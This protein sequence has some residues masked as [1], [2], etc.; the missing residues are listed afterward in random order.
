VVAE[1][2]RIRELDINPLLATKEGLIALDARVVLHPWDV[3]DDRLPRPAIR[4]YPS[5]YVAP[6]TL[7]DGPEVMIRP[8]RPE[9]EPAMVAFHAA[10]S[11]E[12]V[13]MRYFATIPLETRTRHDALVRGCFIDYDR[14]MAL[15]AEQRDKV[16][17]ERRIIGVGRLIRVRETDDAEFAVAV[18]DQFQGQGL[19]TELL[20]RLVLIGKD[21]KV[22][23]IFGEILVENQ[24]MREVC[25]R[26]GF[27]F[28][29][30]RS[31][32]VTAEIEP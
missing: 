9:D 31:G 16:T 21:E 3:E 2:P 19:G 13:H 17:G 25:S 30:P 5:Q 4:P 14:A 6:W 18:A 15:V 26:L 8:I 22:R 28:R 32:V 29:P 27:R 24:P 1:H 23:R 11:P 12:T 10:L 7:R 20:R